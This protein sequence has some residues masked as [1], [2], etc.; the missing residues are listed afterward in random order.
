MPDGAVQVIN[1]PSQEETMSNDDRNTTYEQLNAASVEA[2]ASSMT[3]DYERLRITYEN[4][5]LR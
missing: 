5:Q 2:A 3:T 1:E 4:I